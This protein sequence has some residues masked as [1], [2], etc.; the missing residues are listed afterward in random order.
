[1]SQYYVPAQGRTMPVYT[2]LLIAPY[3]TVHRTWY[4]HCQE[5]NHLLLLCAS[6]AVLAGLAR[7]QGSLGRLSVLRVA[8][9]RVVYLPGS[10]AI[11]GGGL[12]YIYSMPVGLQ[13]GLFCYW[14]WLSVAVMILCEPRSEVRELAQVLLL[15][16]LRL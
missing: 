3:D 14:R 12:R 8:V 11:T 15:V 6:F 5:M 4:S 2:V 1:M 10:S 16:W 13:S 9:G 7:A